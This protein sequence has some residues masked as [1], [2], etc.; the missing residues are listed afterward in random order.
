MTEREKKLAELLPFYRKKCLEHW[1]DDQGK[2]KYT[3]YTQD[4]EYGNS[5]AAPADGDYPCPICTQEK[6]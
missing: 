4:D 2:L 5:C 6:P 3:G 1:L